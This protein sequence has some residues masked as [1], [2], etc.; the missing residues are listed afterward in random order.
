M[1]IH[2]ECLTDKYLISALM[3]KHRFSGRNIID[4]GNKDRVLKSVEKASAGIGIIHQDPHAHRRRAMNS[5]TETGR[6][7]SLIL[8]SHKDSA[9]YIVEICPRLEDWL[10]LRSQKSHIDPS[11]FNLDVSAKHWHVLQINRNQSY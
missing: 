7:G 9:K 11:K 3:R 4:S 5:Y 8:Y 6:I 2:V 1:R 10:L